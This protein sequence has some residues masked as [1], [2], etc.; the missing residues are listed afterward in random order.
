M[1]SL[2]FQVILVPGDTVIVAGE[3]DIFTILTVLGGAGELLLLLLL[4]EQ[5]TSIA[6][7]SRIKL[8]AVEILFFIFLILSHELKIITYPLHFVNN[9]EKLP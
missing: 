9:A 5:E 7:N 4:L 2:L 1:L 6:E 3:K 8:T